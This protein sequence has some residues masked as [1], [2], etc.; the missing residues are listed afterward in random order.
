MGPLSSIGSPVHYQMNSNEKRKKIK[1]NFIT[2]HVHN[3]SQSPG[4][5]RHLNWAASVIHILTSDQ[6]FGGIQRDGSDS[7]I[8]QMLGHF[9]D[10]SI[11]GSL[12]LKGVQNR[13]QVVIKLHINNCTNNLS[14]SPNT[15]YFL[16]SGSLRGWLL[17]LLSSCLGWGLDGLL[18]RGCGC[19]CG[20]CFS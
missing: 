20:S 7:L 16:G 13:R 19:G 1:N 11:A 14:N 8:S 15:E 5:N 10:Q 9:Q 2:D 3:P 12:D 17:N 6:S 4:T 18:G